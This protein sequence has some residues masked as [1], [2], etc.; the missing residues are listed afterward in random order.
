MNTEQ[1]IALLERKRIS[2]EEQ[3]LRPA[4]MFSQGLIGGVNANVASRA[5]EG[6]SKLALWK[7]QLAN[8]D[9]TDKAGNP[10]DAQQTNV[11]FGYIAKHGDLPPTVSLKPKQIS[12][13]TMGEGGKPVITGAVPKGAKDM[14][15]KITTMLSP[16]GEKVSEVEGQV[17]VLPQIKP[18]DIRSSEDKA[19]DVTESRERAKELI[20]AQKAYTDVKSGYNVTMTQLDEV[21]KLND[22]SYSGTLEN[23]KLLIP[24]L[25]G[26]GASNQ[27]FQNTVNV[28]NKLKNYVIKSLRSSFGGQITEGEREYLNGLF[29][30]T[31]KGTKEERAIAI[32]N[33]QEF[34]NMKLKEKE[35][36]YTMWGGDISKIGGTPVKP[37]QS[38]QTPTAQP[39]GTSADTGGIPQVGQT[40]QGGKVLKIKR[41]R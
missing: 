23:A 10:L 40:Y 16:T 19:Y 11:I 36:A 4:Q 31:E 41:I 32:S 33:I 12:T 39:Q 22:N 14:S 1:A 3:R 37:Y 35:E 29:G 8:Y 7:T 26:K 9:M 21:K 27:E 38:Q 20:K 6:E 28:V 24:R 13:F 25:T 30:A 15:P 5:K 17:R 34:L 2:D 18:T